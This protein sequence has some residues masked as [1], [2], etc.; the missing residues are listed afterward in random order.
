M[1][2]HFNLSYDHVTKY[3]VDVTMHPMIMMMR[4]NHSI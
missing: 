3:H 2:F 1:R 4:K